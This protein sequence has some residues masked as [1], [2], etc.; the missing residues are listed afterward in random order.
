MEPYVKVEMDLS[1]V[2][3]LG[4]SQG[5]SYTCV[6]QAG[7]H[8]NYPTRGVTKQTMKVF[9][10]G[11]MVFYSTVGPTHGAKKGN[12]SGYTHLGFGVFQRVNGLGLV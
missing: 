12:S 11:N 3:V 5:T 4:S 8:M 6:A 10:T 9:Y 2:Y 1:E 7:R